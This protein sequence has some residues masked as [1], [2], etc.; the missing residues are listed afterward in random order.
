MQVYIVNCNYICCPRFVVCPRRPNAIGDR[1]EIT[2]KTEHFTDLLGPK[3]MTIKG[4]KTTAEGCNGTSERSEISM[5]RCTQAPSMFVFFNLVKL[6]IRRGWWKLHL[7]KVRGMNT[8]FFMIC[9]PG[10]NSWMITSL[11]YECSEH[12]VKTLQP[13]FGGEPNFFP[14]WLLFPLLSGEK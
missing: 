13:S 11:H 9:F 10:I 8:R 5:R 3:A 7:F 14:I 4:I 6:F 2:S 12:S 1:S